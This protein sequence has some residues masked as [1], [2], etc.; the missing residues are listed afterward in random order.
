MKKKTCLTLEDGRLLED[1]MLWHD[2]AG[3]MD[4]PVSWKRKKH[5][6]WSRSCQNS[7]QGS[8]VSEKE[9]E[10]GREGDDT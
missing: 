8:Y 7:S 5:R 3:H 4:A 2:K 10:E 6:S 9:M 1:G